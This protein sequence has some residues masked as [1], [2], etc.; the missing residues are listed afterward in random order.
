MLQEIC[1]IRSQMFRC[2][3][4]REGLEWKAHSSDGF[5]RGGEDLEWKA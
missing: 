3:K 1:K 5:V 4:L 2:I